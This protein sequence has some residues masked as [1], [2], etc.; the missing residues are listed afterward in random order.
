[1]AILILMATSLWA[2]PPAFKA[3][4][5][6]K[7]PDTPEGLALDANGDMYSTLFHTGEVIK[8]NDNGTYEH[9]A[10]VPSKEQ[11]SQGVLQGL[12]FDKEGNMYTAFKG[13]TNSTRRK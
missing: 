11:G 4:V 6:A 9:I 1:M 2:K 8:L 5:V 3:W 12:D 13:R 7:L 10:W